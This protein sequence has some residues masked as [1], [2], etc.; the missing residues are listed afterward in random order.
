MMGWFCKATREAKRE[1]KTKGSSNTN[2]RRWFCLPFGTGRSSNSR[3]WHDPSVSSSPHLRPIRQFS[4]AELK[5]ATHNF[6]NI[7]ADDNDNF[8]IYRAQLPHMEFVRVRRTNL[9]NRGT[10]EQFLSELKVLSS[11]HHR[12]LVSLVGFCQ[13]GGE[14]LLVYEHV[15]GTL[16]EYLHDPH[17]PGNPLSWTKRLDIALGVA[18]GLSHLHA[19]GD[20]PIVHR[21]MKSSSIL[22]NCKLVPK[23]SEVGLSRQMTE[24]TE[25]T[26]ET[27]GYLPPEHYATGTCSDKS[28]VYA[29]G[30]VLL[31]ILT[32]M[33]S[34][35]RERFQHR[36]K[37]LLVDLVRSAYNQRGWRTVRR[38]VDPHIRNDAYDSSQ[39]RF[40]Q[41]A[42]DC[43]EEDRVKR[44]TMRDV[45]NRLEELVQRRPSDP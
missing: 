4:L 34:F 5:R 11:V 44:P 26:R 19:H 37:V 39:K 16:S 43:L 22:L 45:T 2:V 24:G 25:Q 33:K 6:N 17:H 28:D 10:L 35:D 38:K 15:E 12:N 36:Q 8:T 14:H 41:I 32:G 21:N 30:V 42:M 23:V 1:I 18:R 27:Q 31:E 29:F 9:E 3:I 20:P 7:L 13:E 40:L